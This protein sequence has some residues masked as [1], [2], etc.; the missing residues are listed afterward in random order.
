MQ[1]WPLLVL[2]LAMRTALAHMLRAD[3]AAHRQDTGIEGP[4]APRS[5]TWSLDLPVEDQPGPDQDHATD[6]G[7]GPPVD[8]RRFLPQQSGADA[9]TAAPEPAVPPRREGRVPVEPDHLL[10]IISGRKAVRCPSACPA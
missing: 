10:T 1:S 7:S 2:V 9:R 4:A 6:S 8:A 5:S 3:D